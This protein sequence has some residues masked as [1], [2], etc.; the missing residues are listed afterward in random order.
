MQRQISEMVQHSK[1]PQITI[2]NTELHCCKEN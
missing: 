1:T 2:S